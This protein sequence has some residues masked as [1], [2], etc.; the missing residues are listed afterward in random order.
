MVSLTPGRITH[1]KEPWKELIRRLGGLQSRSGDFGGEKNL[2]FLMPV[3]ETRT[4][5]PLAE[6]LY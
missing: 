6:S 4:V 1:R 5:Q 3:F 2:L